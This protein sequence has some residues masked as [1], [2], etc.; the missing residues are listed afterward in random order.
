MAKEMRCSVNTSEGTRFFKHST[1]ERCFVN[2]AQEK[3]EHCSEKLAK[4]T[5]H[6]YIHK[7]YARCAVL[8]QIT[9]KP[10]LVFYHALKNI[11]SVL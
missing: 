5:D 2:T 8:K 6:S 1:E 11:N 4:E 7:P 3:G 10:V 9:R